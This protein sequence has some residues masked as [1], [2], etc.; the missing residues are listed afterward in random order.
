MKKISKAFKKLLKLLLKDKWNLIIAVLIILV[1]IL[2]INII[3]LF[4]TLIIMGI[5]VLL[6]LGLKFG[7]AI[8]MARKRKKNLLKERQ[9]RN[10]RK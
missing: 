5:I 10:G 2:G 4:K 6:V 3:G 8:I 9:K 1:L 7:G